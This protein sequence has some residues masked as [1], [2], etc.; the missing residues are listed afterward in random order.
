MKPILLILP[1]IFSLISCIEVRDPNEEAQVIEEVT[2]Q[3]T[4]EVRPLPQ[5]HRYAVLIKGSIDTEDVIEQPGVYEYSVQKGGRQFNLQV[6]IPQDY[7]VENEMTLEQLSPVTI[8][9]ENQFRVLETKGRVFFNARSMLTLMG[10][11]LL[12]KAS[13]IESEGAL[14]QTFPINQTAGLGLDG[15]HGGHIKFEAQKIRGTLQVIMRG[16]NAVLDAKL[17]MIIPPFEAAQKA[18]RLGTHRPAAGRRTARARR[19]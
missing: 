2:H 3:P 13:S 8:L 12:I 16:E 11:K 18:G 14:L 5:P 1:L 6:E 7:V 17:A 9:D 4:V 10:E 15:R 19:R